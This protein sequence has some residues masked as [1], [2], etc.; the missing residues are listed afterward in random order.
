MVNIYDPHFDEPREHDGFRARRA[1]L[2]HQLAIERV[3]LSLW[4]LESGQAA[5]PCHF[6]LAGTSC[7]SSSTAGRCSE[8]GDVDPA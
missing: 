8:V 2:G 1:R 4:E 3:G 7:S 6:H 5:D